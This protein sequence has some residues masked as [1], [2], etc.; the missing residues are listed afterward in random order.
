MAPASGC[1]CK[2]IT[3]SGRPPVAWLRNSKRF[4]RSATK[5]ARHYSPTTGC[6]RRQKETVD[7]P[8]NRTA[9]ARN[10]PRLQSGQ[11]DAAV[12]MENRSREVGALFAGQ[13]QRGVGD[14]GRLAETVEQ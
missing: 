14:V 4:Q 5:V 6:G 2:L 12:G 8:R 10:E 3:T 13:E 7:F 1:G 11:H 9:A